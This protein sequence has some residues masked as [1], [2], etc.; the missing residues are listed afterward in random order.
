MDN[1]GQHIIISGPLNSK[2]IVWTYF[3]HKTMKTISRIQFLNVKGNAI[4]GEILH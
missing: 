1:F 4:H 3:D 2:K